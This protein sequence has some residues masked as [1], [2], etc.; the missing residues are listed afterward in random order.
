[1]LCAFS[2]EMPEI[3][4]GI[5]M[6][7]MDT[8]ECRHSTQGWLLRLVT[9]FCI[10]L[11]RIYLIQAE[12]GWRVNRIWAA[13]RNELSDKD[14]CRR[15]RRVREELSEVYALGIAS[16]LGWKYRAVS[17]VKKSFRIAN[18]KKDS[19]LSVLLSMLSW[20]GFWY[21]R[22]LLA[23]HGESQMRAQDLSSKI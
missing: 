14:W 23:K 8:P 2:R 9:L 16:G 20:A 15:R 10:S 1:M 13:S 3:V 6:H 4:G 5:R 18:R 19:R 11:A 22:L 21:G 12:C 17:D 7:I